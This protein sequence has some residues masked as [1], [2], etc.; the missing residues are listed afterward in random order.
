MQSFAFI[1]NFYLTLCVYCRITINFFHFQKSS[2]KNCCIDC[3]IWKFWWRT[4]MGS[5]DDKISI[6]FM[7][8][9][10]TKPSSFASACILAVVNM[11]PCVIWF[12]LIFI[13][14]ATVQHKL[15]CTGWTELFFYCVKCNNTLGWHAYFISLKSSSLY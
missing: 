15:W 1:L 4:Y 14:N 13:Q 12:I 5:F 11:P 8:Q 7:P 3:R 9:F 2:N 10:L 6:G